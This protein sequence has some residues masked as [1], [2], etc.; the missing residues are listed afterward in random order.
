MVDM[1]ITK[2]MWRLIIGGLQTTMFIFVF[3]AIFGVLL[4]IGLTCLCFNRKCQWLYEPL[5]WFVRTVR[6]VPAVALMMFF[7][8]VIFAG[9]WN[10]I[11]VT[12]I[13]LSVYTSGMLADLFSLHIQQVDRGQIEAGLSLGLTKSQCY[14]YIIIP[15]AARSMFPLIAGE[16]QSLLQATS[17]V[18]YIGQ[19][20][21]MKVVD[22]IREQYNDAFFPLVIS[23]A[24]Y[25]ALSWLITIAFNY[26]SEKFFKHD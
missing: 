20:D 13:A 7:Y 3:A 6:N 24:L 16:L 18:G 12:I 5:I 9:E 1:Y 19:D 23:S 11:V 21:L 15:Q 10:G 2:E 17:F 4:S 14:R 22:G 25:L 26:L 8:Y